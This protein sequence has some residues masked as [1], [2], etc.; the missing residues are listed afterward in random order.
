MDATTR[1]CRW[2]QCADWSP[3]LDRNNQYRHIVEIRHAA[4]RRDATLTCRTAQS[5]ALA[6]H[7]Q[8]RDCQRPAVLDRL[9][10]RDIGATWVRLPG[11]HGRCLAAVARHRSHQG[12][13]SLL[14]VDPTTDGP[15]WYENLEILLL[16]DCSGGHHARRGMFCRPRVTLIGNAQSLLFRAKDRHRCGLSVRAMD[17]GQR[18]PPS[19]MDVCSHAQGDSHTH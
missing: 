12:C 6:R 15:R 4:C 13:E 5:D 9:S 7:R 18:G 19:S 1:G 11:L 3:Q 2:H 8:G 17:I 14:T 16:H 10:H